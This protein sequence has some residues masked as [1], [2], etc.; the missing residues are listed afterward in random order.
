MLFFYYVK[1]K[2]KKKT[3]KNSIIHTNKTYSTKWN[4]SH[5]I[6]FTKGNIASKS[7]TALFFK[8]IVCIQ[9][10]DNYV[11]ITYLEQDSIKNALIRTKISSIK[12]DFPKLL[13][14]HRSYLIN[15]FHF[16]R[17]QVKNG[18]TVL[19]LANDI[20]IPV[21]RTYIEEVKSRLDTA[22]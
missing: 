19:V 12:N 8:D 9:S 1:I 22:D 18:K 13:Q 16:K 4:A 7:A 17:W 6:N 21:S 20:D 2:K 15:P 3:W 11:E 10:A 14:T 5:R